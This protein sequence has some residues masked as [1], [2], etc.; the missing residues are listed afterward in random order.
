L[1]KRFHEDSEGKGMGL[2]IAKTQIVAM[3][4][5]IE[6]ESEVNKGTKLTIE[7]PDTPTSQPTV[8]FNSFGKALESAG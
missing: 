2:F 7:F 4:G 1:Y 6:I 5:T 8:V 3:G